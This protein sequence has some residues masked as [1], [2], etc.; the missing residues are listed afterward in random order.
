MNTQQTDNLSVWRGLCLL[1]LTFNHLLLWP[2]ENISFALRLT[3]Q[4]LGWA[5]FATVFF[6][7]AGIQWGRKLQRSALLWRWNL[8]RCGR[9]MA[10]VFISTAIFVIAVRLNFVQPAPWQRHLDWSSPNIPIWA[11]L[12]LRIPWLIDVIWLHAWLG[13]FATLL[14]SIPIV[15][16]SP[17]CIA[18]LSVLVWLAG[19]AGYFDSFSLHDAAPSWHSWTGWQLLFV[20]CALSQQNEF[21][22]WFRIFEKR[23]VLALPLIIAVILFVV[24]QFQ[25]LKFINDTF[26]TKNFGPLFAFNSF[27]LALLASS[28]R[29]PI[30]PNWLVF[31]GRHSLFFYSLQC[32]FIYILGSH[33][34][35]S[36]NEKFVAMFVSLSS[37]GFYFGLAQLLMHRRSL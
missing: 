10:W 27:V 13:I 21:K 20:G 5:S 1:G 7:I 24:K 16:H 15:R 11:V 29:F 6:A 22:S 19:Q 23:S 17:F 36:Q 9:L 33:V 18:A 30:V 25:I 2:C 12:G 35:L 26:Q 3:Y 28:C 31:L 37:L 32:F 34:S 14:W 4:S 8:A